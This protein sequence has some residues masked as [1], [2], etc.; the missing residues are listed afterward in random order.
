MQ[1][2]AAEQRRGR[3][4]ACAAGSVSQSALAKVTLAMAARGSTAGAGCPMVQIPPT[5]PSSPCKAP[6]GGLLGS[7]GGSQPFLRALETTSLLKATNNPEGW[8]ARGTLLLPFSRAEPGAGVAMAMPLRGGGC[9]RGSRE[10][11]A[12]RPAGGLA[13]RR[14]QHTPPVI[15]A[16]SI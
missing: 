16:R 14:S 2:S 8:R 5:N 15:D 9:S 12:S 1:T 7:R 10:M 4:A 13:G 11:G 6:S 3:V